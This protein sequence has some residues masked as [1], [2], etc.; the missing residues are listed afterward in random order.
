[1]ERVFLSLR[2][3]GERLPSVGSAGGTVDEPPFL[4]TAEGRNEWTL[5]RD[6][7]LACGGYGWEDWKVLGD[8]TWRDVFLCS[9]SAARA[10][11]AS[12]SRRLRVAIKFPPHKC[13]QCDTH[14]TRYICFPCWLM[15][16]VIA[17]GDRTSLPTPRYLSYTFFRSRAAAPDEVSR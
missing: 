2:T 11:G 8:G 3:G 10:P 4:K 16:A 7:R 15:N 9:A 1:M 12:S 17:N 6:R 5:M 14:P 13:K